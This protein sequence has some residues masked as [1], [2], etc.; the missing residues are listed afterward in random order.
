MKNRK[1]IITAGIF[2]LLVTAFVLFLPQITLLIARIQSRGAISKQ[3]ASLHQCDGKAT[4]CV[5]AGG[6]VVSKP[7]TNADLQYMQRGYSTEKD[8]HIEYA[9]NVT[10]AVVAIR[11]YTHI[12]DL[13]LSL[14]KDNA[15]V[16]ISYYC[17]PDNKCWAVNNQT[18][19]VIPEAK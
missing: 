3:Q 11:A 7:L 4:I 8:Q 1:V 15:P 6:Q 14:L 12:P 16:H 13:N 18:H 10:A 19:Q 17:S 9:Q 2:G 5:V